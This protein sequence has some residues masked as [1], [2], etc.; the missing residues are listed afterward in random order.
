MRAPKCKLCGSEHWGLC[1]VQ[2]R[3][4]KAMAAA[5]PAAKPPAKKAKARKGKK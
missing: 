3:A 4:L 1:Y 2:P 5:T